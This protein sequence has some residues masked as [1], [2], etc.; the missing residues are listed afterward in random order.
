MWQIVNV[1]TYIIILYWTYLEY[2][3]SILHL[4]K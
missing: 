4:N 1:S 3:N 2:L